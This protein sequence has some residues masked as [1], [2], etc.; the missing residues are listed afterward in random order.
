MLLNVAIGLSV[1]ALLALAASPVAGIVLLFIAK[2][3]VDTTFAQPLLFGLRLTEIVGALVPVA[4]LGHMFL[5][6]DEQ[7]VGR[8]PLHRLWLLYALDVL[9][10]SLLIVYHQDLKSGANVF[11]RHINGFI[12]FYMVQA[13]FHHEKGLKTLL[14]AMLAA[15]LFPMAV[16]VYQLATGT[17]WIEAQA[18][19]LTR[20]IGLYH[21]AFT[22]RAY[23]FQ[24]ILAL[25]LYGALYARTNPMVKAATLAYMAVAVVVMT[26]AYSKAGILSLALWSGCWTFLQRKYLALSLL[27][28]GGAG[29]AVLYADEIAATVVRLFHKEI[30]ALGGTVEVARTFQGRWYGWQEMV[31]HWWTL[32]WFAKGLG[33]GEVAVGA[34][35]DYLLVLFH[36]GLLGL[37]LYLTLLAAIGWRILR[38]LRRRVDPLRVAA[39]MLYLMWLVDTVGLVPSAY[40]GYQWFVWGLIGLSLRQGA[41]DARSAAE[42][43]PMAAR[44][45]SEAP[46]TGSGLVSMPASVGRRFPIIAP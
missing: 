34:H 26:K 28:A 13:F 24:T 1:L 36:G 6:R 11:L 32:P 19:G 42:L 21:D 35:N 40:P 41:M 3:L 2:P 8:M 44:A 46:V 29:A 15:G 45:G 10:F 5:A 17:V 25:L 23:A 12:G 22:V 20:N 31:H 14:L 18:E 39:L 4:V 30:G 9:V 37:G 33:S 43:E 38:D 27:V 16:G 7:A